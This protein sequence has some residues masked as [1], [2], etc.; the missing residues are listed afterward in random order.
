MLSMTT[1]EPFSALLNLLEEKDPHGLDQNAPG[2][3]LDSGKTM[4]WLCIAGFSRALEEVAKVT[5]LGARK[6]TPN[7]WAS[8]PEGTTRYMEAFGR[9]LLKLGQG[10]LKDTGPNGLGDVYHISQCIWNLLA[11]HELQLRDL[12]SQKNI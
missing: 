1:L 8:V 5:T 7:G 11:A 2:A 9:H 4:P 3:K 6:Y 10:E 12:D